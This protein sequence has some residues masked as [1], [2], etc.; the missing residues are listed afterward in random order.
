MQHGPLPASSSRGK[1]GHCSRARRRGYRRCCFPRSHAA[2]SNPHLEPPSQRRNAGFLLAFVFHTLHILTRGFGTALLLLTSST[3]L[4]LYTAVDVCAYLVYKVLRNDFTSAHFP[5]PPL[6][7]F[8]SSLLVRV[9]V[10]KLLLDFTVR[11][12]P[13]PNALAPPSP[14]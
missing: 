8:V 5:A 14:T 12:P 7:A 11:A 1:H 9:L 10:D 4:A 2:N 13:P 6:L 3:W